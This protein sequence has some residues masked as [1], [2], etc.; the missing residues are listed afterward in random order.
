MTFIYI[1]IVSVRLNSHCELFDVVKFSIF[2]DNSML[3]N[4]VKSQHA[5]LL[6]IS[7]DSIIFL[8]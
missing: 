4:L 2:H 7:T 5:D 1:L 8:H 6:S 3:M